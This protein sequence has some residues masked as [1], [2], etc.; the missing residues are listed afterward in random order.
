MRKLATRMQ[1]VA[2]IIRHGCQ[3]V[4]GSYVLMQAK[5]L[6]G[7]LMLH[8][9]LMP[10][11]GIGTSGSSAHV[12]QEHQKHAMARLATLV[13]PFNA[14]SPSRIIQG[15]HY[16]VWVA[17]IGLGQHDDAVPVLLETP[18]WSWAP[19]PT[20]GLNCKQEALSPHSVQFHNLLHVG[21]QCQRP[22]L[23]MH[24]SFS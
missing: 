13:W 11:H 15:V 16:F 2:H 23:L 6:H 14:L 19:N 7:S 9:L 10:V 4:C 22:R 24:D 5:G 18:F 21:E 8:H 20:L 12:E 17:W 3:R 1:A